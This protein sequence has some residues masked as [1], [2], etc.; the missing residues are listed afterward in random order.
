[1]PVPSV[2]PLAVQ[3]EQH[4]DQSREKLAHIA[5][6]LSTVAHK[7]SIIHNYLVR[8]QHSPVLAASA[9]RRYPSAALRRYPSA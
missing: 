2:P 9:M 4:S 8:P 1:M 3:M 7:D 5:H 6:T